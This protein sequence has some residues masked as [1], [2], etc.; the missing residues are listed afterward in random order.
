WSAQEMNGIFADTFYFLALGNRTD[1]AYAKALGLS[2]RLKGPLVTTTWVLTE[3]ADACAAPNRRLAFLTWL[4]TLQADPNVT[5]VPPSRP[6][7]YRW[8]HCPR[9]GH[10]GRPPTAAHQ[11]GRRAGPLRTPGLLAGEQAARLPVHQ[12]RPRPPTIGDRSGTSS[13]PAGVHSRPPR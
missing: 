13:Q 11:R 9:A 4:R 10:Q 5:I 7:R 1:E 3:L 6:G 2:Q 12:P 8:T